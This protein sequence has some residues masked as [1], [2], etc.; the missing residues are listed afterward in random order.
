LRALWF[1]A[2]VNLKSLSLVEERGGGARGVAR[3]NLGLVA[4]GEKSQEA[5]SRAHGQTVIEHGVEVLEDVEGS[6]D[7]QHQVQG[8]VV[9][10]RE[11]GGLVVGNLVLLPQHPLILLLLGHTFVISQFPHHLLGNSILTLQG[12]LVLEDK[13]DILVGHG[14][15]VGTDK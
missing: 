4:C 15:K 1:E 13:L 6:H 5:S 10:D 12:N 8:V 11:G 14:N 9:E 3:V 2:G 7:E